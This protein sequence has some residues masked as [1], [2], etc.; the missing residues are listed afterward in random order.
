[1]IG[2][3]LRR[4]DFKRLRPDTAANVEDATQQIDAW[5][6]ETEDAGILRSRLGHYEFGKDLPITILL[7][8]YRRR[9]RGLLLGRI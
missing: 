6:N 1:M 2:V 7:V 8:R 4:S 5:L 3:H 9:L